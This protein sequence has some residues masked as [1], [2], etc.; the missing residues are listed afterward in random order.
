MVI[1]EKLYTIS[2]E[3]LAGYY[4]G[5]RCAMLQ[6]QEF[7]NKMTALQESTATFTVRGER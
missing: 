5:F 4:D 1:P 3:Y 7:I 2:P 6:M